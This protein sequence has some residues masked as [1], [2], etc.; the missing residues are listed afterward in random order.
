MIFGGVF[1]NLFLLSASGTSSAVEGTDAMATLLNY[2]VLALFVVL[3]YF[4]LF[5]PQRKKQKQETE[6]RKN[7]QVG[8]EI[9]TIGGIVGRVVSM[10]DDTLLIETGSDRAKIRIK[11]VAVASCNP[12]KLDD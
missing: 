6:M 10:K 5:R 7:L 3:M 4:F 8:D 11:T 12:V 1:V 9:T 2:G